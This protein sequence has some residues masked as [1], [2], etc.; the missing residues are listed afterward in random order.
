MLSSAQ[1]PS[2]CPN[3]Q[4]PKP[5]GPNR[6][7]HSATVDGTPAVDLLL[8][9][10][11]SVAAL[12]PGC[13]QACRQR[14]VGGWALLGGP[15]ASGGQLS[16]PPVWWQLKPG[17][18]GQQ[19]LAPRGWGTLAHTYICTGHVR[20]TAA[21]AWHRHA[22][23]AC[24]EHRLDT[25]LTYCQLLC[26]RPSCGSPHE[27]AYHAMHPREVQRCSCRPTRKANHQSRRNCA[28]PSDKTT[29]ASAN[30]CVECRHGI[31]LACKKLG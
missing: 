4:L 27:R 22:C 28:A 29:K 12:L 21:H 17:N 7:Q 26:A 6:S 16:H 23:M 13:S 18:R 24:K 5:P 25:L 15:R 11:A 9:L 20:G 14:H 2:P 30:C 1:I 3:H 10:A 31:Q 19:Q 8:L